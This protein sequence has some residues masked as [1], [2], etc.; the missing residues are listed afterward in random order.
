MRVMW[1]PRGIAAM[2]CMDVAHSGGKNSSQRYICA[3]VVL[4]GR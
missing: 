2:I 3:L 4:L 1:R